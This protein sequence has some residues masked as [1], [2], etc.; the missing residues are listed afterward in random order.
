MKESNTRWAMMMA[1]AVHMYI[2]QIRQE[3]EYTHFSHTYHSFDCYC[4]KSCAQTQLVMK[5]SS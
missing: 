4:R 5:E 3:R 1:G 2:S